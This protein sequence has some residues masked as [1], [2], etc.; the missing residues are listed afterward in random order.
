MWKCTKCNRHFANRNQ[1][2]SCLTRPLKEHFLGRKKRAEAIFKEL[3][4][5]IKSNGPVT[6]VS[7]KTRIAFQTR[8]SFA[9]IM[10]RDDFLRGH[11]VLAER[12][13]DPRFCKIQ[14]ISPRNHVHEFILTDPHEIDTR[15]C[16]LI[17]KAYAVGNQEHLQKRDNLR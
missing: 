1:S 8:M 13:P 9:A 16:E 17:T 11:L 10:V 4:K 3:L 5:T 15:F 7:S 6:I 12:V 14:T 2:H